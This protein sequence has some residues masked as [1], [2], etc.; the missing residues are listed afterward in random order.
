MS[1]NGRKNTQHEA[2]W[3]QSVVI[4]KGLAQKENKENICEAIES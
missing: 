2:G 1:E 3:N 4:Q